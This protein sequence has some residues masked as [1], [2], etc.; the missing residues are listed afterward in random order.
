MIKSL[1]NKSY[2]YKS[3]MNEFGLDDIIL[4]KNL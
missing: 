3:S 2:E 1:N 4:D